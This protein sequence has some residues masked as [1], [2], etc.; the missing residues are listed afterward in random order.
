MCVIKVSQKLASF[1]LF[2]IQISFITGTMFF[3]LNHYYTILLKPLD[4]DWFKSK[5]A[6]TSPYS[7]SSTC[8]STYPLQVQAWQGLFFFTP[9]MPPII[10]YHRTI[11]P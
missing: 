6:T 11:E 8:M 5:K 3:I 4:L 7:K 2:N 9:N 1:N 10:P